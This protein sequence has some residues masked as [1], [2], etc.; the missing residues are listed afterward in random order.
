[1]TYDAVT[2]IALKSDP[3][4]FAKIVYRDY[5][6]ENS[7]AIINR[8]IFTSISLKQSDRHLLTVTKSSSRL[9]VVLTCSFTQS[10]KLKVTIF[11]LVKT[12]RRFSDFK[13]ITKT[14][15][16]TSHWCTASKRTSAKSTY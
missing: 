16:A 14:R 9:R 5:C 4:P 6:L 15:T 13:T 11:T 2:A 8:W 3:D 10:I 12:S 1:M 7:I